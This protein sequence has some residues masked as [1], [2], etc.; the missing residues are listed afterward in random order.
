MSANGFGGWRLV[1]ASALFVV[2]LCIAVL[3][4]FGVSAPV[5]AGS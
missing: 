2:A 1:S 4:T 5:P 3:W